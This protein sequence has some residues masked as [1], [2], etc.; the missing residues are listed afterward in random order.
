MSEYL[1]KKQ[2]LEAL[3]EEIYVYS[4]DGDERKFDK[5]VLYLAN[6][7][8]ATINLHAFDAIDRAIEAEKERDALR[9]AIRLNVHLWERDGDE[10]PASI[11]LLE[12]I[13][14]LKEALHGDHNV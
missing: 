8:K 13:K 5:G 12:G 10:F 9:E 7:L 1:D 3:E 4:N 2:L 14:S 11:L 6:K